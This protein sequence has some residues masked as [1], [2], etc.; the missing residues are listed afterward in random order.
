MEFLKERRAEKA[1]QRRKKKQE[2]KLARIHKEQPEKSVRL[3][4][5]QED[6][7]KR[8]EDTFGDK[9]KRKEK[10][11]FNVERSSQAR[12][13]KNEDKS[14]FSG[15]SSSASSNKAS[16][17]EGKEEKIPYTRTF[18]SSKMEGKYKGQQQQQQQQPDRFDKGSKGKKGDASR[19]GDEPKEKYQEGEFLSPYEL[20]ESR[21]IM[22]FFPLQ[23]LAKRNILVETSGIREIA[24]KIVVC[25]VIVRGICRR[26]EKK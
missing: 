6:Q 23:N 5:H 3:K 26:I 19:Q 22:I 2:E 8:K 13:T 14:F 25:I 15:N 20:K 12:Q 24:R 21:E 17:I 4:D 11:D 9:K 1:K 16:H 7:K 10:E 18:N